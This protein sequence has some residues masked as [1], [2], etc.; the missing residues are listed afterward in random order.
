MLTKTHATST[1]LRDHVA[2]RPANDAKAPPPQATA[3][4]VI[5]HRILALRNDLASLRDTASDP[6]RRAQGIMLPISVDLGKPNELSDG[7][8]AAIDAELLVSEALINDI[9]DRLAAI[10]TIV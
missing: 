9:R 1:D 8:L 6:I 7:T 3:L 10:S 4:D 5:Y 2:V